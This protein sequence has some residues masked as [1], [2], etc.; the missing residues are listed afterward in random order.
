M[1]EKD[2]AYF[3]SLDIHGHTMIFKRPAKTLITVW[4]FIRLYS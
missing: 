1:P 3:I 4:T 2:K